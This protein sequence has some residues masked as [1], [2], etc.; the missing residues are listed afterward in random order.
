MVSLT[1]AGALIENSD[2]KITP[3]FG[4]L[5]P[6]LVEGVWFGQSFGVFYNKRGVGGKTIA[7]QAW[8]A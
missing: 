3:F 7:R 2:K 6:Y 5:I 1:T 8:N 4:I